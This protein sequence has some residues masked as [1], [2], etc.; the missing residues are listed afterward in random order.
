MGKITIFSDLEDQDDDLQDQ[1]HLV[2]MRLEKS[3]SR[4]AIPHSL[5]Q[6][7]RG[8]RSKF[9]YLRLPSTHL[10]HKIASRYRSAIPVP[11]Y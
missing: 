1:D 11:L 5:E 4:R 9:S 8:L 7:G 2:N 3:L 10:I 6:E